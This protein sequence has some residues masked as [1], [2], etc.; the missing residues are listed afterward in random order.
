VSPDEARLVF[1]QEAAQGW[2]LEFEGEL[3]LGR[4]EGNVSLVRRA[5]VVGRR[6]TPTHRAYDVRFLQTAEEREEVLGLL[7]RI[8]NQRKS[9]R[10][11]PAAQRPIRARLLGLP[12]MTR[13]L[14]EVVDISEGGLC[15]LF[16]SG[17]DKLLRDRSE[18]RLGIRLP[19]Y[20]D[21][22][23]FQAQLVARNLTSA[24]LAYHI[25]FSPPASAGDSEALQAVAK[26]VMEVQQESLGKKAH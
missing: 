6:D 21:E 18:V 7:H 15:L 10:V 1:T 23:E 19:G 25:A 4:N 24:G 5:R 12:S 22:L 13:L 20:E 8:F 16:G 2:P 11:Q 26:Y 14:P 17:V 3:S 9:V